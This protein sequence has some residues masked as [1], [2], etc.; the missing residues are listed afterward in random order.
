MFVTKERKDKELEDLEGAAR[1]LIDMVDPPQ[2]DV[3][4]T[5]SLVERMRRVPI[6]MAGRE[7]G[8]SKYV[9]RRMLGLARSWYPQLDFSPL[10]HGVP[11]D[12]TLP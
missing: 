5:E 4:N 7:M 1:N 9:A 3:I 8:T 10:E 12:Y 2:P 6:Q 11:S